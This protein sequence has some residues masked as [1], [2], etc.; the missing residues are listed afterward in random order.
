ML[1][2]RKFDRELPLIF[3]LRRLIRTIRLAES[4]PAIFARRGA[5]MTDSADCR[6][7][8]AHS[9]TREELRPVTTH[10]CVVIGKISDIRKRAVG[11][12]RRRN[13]VTGVALETLVFLGRV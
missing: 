13:L 6:A 5:Q 3:G 11:G 9:L 4:E 2:M 8:A 7:S 1:V 12:P 10:A